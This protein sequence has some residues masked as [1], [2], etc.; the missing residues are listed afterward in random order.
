MDVIL[1]FTESDS[2]I[3]LGFFGAD[4]Y[5]IKFIPTDILTKLFNHSPNI[6]FS[7]KLFRKIRTKSEEHIQLFRFQINP[8]FLSVRLINKYKD[9]LNL[10][11]FCETMIRNH[12]KCL[13]RAMKIL[14]NIKVDVTAQEFETFFSYNTG[15]IPVNIVPNMLEILSIEEFYTPE[16]S[17]EIRKLF[18]QEF[19]N[20]PK[21][22][23]AKNFVEK[24]NK[25]TIEKLKMELN[26]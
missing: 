20:L 16:Y 18:Y 13:S 5:F 26:L 7:E 11:E 1:E 12:E 3:I 24:Y 14:R 21:E 8:L 17:L 6:L 15:N 4:S 25:G 19:S 9:D 22:R 2:E 10:K 23:N